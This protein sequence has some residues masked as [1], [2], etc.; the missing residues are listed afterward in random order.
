MQ[1]CSQLMGKPPVP[2]ES[3]PASQQFRFLTE[4]DVKWYHLV[5]GFIC[6]AAAAAITYIPVVQAVV[7]T[8]I[9]DWATRPE[10][11]NW[12]DPA[13]GAAAAAVPAA[14]IAFGAVAVLWA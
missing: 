5:L 8:R 7:N 4:V 14:G 3:R 6:A 10:V 9:A 11:E 1:I 13:A 2:R 12:A